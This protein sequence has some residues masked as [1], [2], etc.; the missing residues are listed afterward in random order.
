VHNPGC[1]ANGIGQCTIRDAFFYANAT[2]GHDTVH[3]DIPGAGVR[4]PFCAGLALTD[5]AGATVDGFSQPGATPNTLATGNNAVW[6]IRCSTEFGASTFGVSLYSPN[7]FVRGL[8]VEGWGIG[9]DIGGAS[10]NRVSGNLIGG[11]PS[12]TGTGVR[13]WSAGV[14]AER[15]IIGGLMPA[16]RNVVYASVEGISIA[17]PGTS[18]TTVQGNIIGAVS[19][20]PGC[21]SYYGIVMGNGTHLNQIG[22]GMPGARNVVSGHAS[23]A[24]VLGSGT[25]ANQVQGNYIGTTVD[26]LG[27]R[28]NTQGVRIEGSRD[29]LIGGTNAGEGNVISGN[30]DGI[31]LSGVGANHNQIFGNKIGT[32]APGTA[33]L[34]NT[35]GIVINS[36]ASENLIGTASFPGA[37]NIISGNFENGLVIANGA[38]HNSILGNSIG[39][40]ALATI[41]LGNARAPFTPGG[42]ITISDASDGNVV[43]GNVIA[44]NGNSEAGGWGIRIRGGTGNRVT[45][46][47]IHS[48]FAL[49]I[50]LGTVGV[51]PNDAGDGDSGPNGLQ[52]FPVIT[53]VSPVPGGTRFQG[54]LEST[55]SEGFQV[56]LF[57]VP[58]C[59]PGGHGE[60]ATLLGALIVNSDVTGSGQ[61]DQ[62]IPVPV[63]TGH[64][65]TATAT[66]SLDETSEFSECFPRAASF[67]TL[68]PCR[69]SDTR[70]P[71]GPWGGPALAASAE[72]R[73]PVAGRCGIPDGA[74]AV[75]FNFTVT[76]PSAGGHLT[77]F[78]AG[79]VRPATSTLNYGSGQTRANNAISTL[80]NAG[81][82]SVFCGQPAGTTHLIIDVNGY[83]E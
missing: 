60:G 66:N 9:V 64:R 59:D 14:T 67:H 24:I 38:T 25:F 43:G 48:N 11:G 57:S 68:V 76:Q 75:S 36:L 34:P 51:T 3:F 10:D 39:T 62:I 56:Q 28:S 1:A 58:Y 69:V 18:S 26:G 77:V 81:S 2:A 8:I 37:R 70:E 72:R 42:G 41:D 80:G 32:D 44:Y 55:P 52:N 33:A 50:D 20:I 40:D 82:I 30:E 7:N 47:S 74:Q 23:W 61:F 65:V 15:N 12:G 53:D 71:A 19:G 21:C 31:F 45:S 29:N 17:D 6:K 46:N 63:P 79:T 4:N 54:T 49:G 78:P 83:F 13:I 5:P 35:T 16:D 73:F 22:G 27:A